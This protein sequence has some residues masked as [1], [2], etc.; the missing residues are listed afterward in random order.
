MIKKSETRITLRLL[1]DERK[2]KH[3]LSTRACVTVYD[4][5]PGTSSD[6][7]MCSVGA[8]DRCTAFDWGSCGEYAVDICKYDYGDCPANFSDKCES[9]YDI[10]NSINN[11]DFCNPSDYS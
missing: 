7:G 4:Y 3:I 10:C 2:S 6:F 8:Q 5:C 1:N 11:S 9:D